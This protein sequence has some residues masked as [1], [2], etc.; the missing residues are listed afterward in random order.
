MAVV[1]AAGT[2]VHLDIVGDGPERLQILSRI[3]DLELQDCIHLHGALAGNG[4]RDVLASCHGFVLPSFAEGL[5]VVLMEALAMG[6]PVITT[7]INGIPELVRTGD[8]GWLIPSGDAAALAEAIQAFARMSPQ[9]LGRMGLAGRELVLQ[10]HQ[11]GR[12]TDRLHELFTTA[13]SSD[14]VRH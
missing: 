3:A 2:Q 12:E 9:E 10:N 8:N 14:H 7:A 1:R 6:R 4:V 13:D 11:I 5:P